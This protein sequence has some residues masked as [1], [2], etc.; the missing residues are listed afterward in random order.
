MSDFD[1]T[2]CKVHIYAKGW[3]GINLEASHEFCIHPS[4]HMIAESF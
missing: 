1:L 4:L 3:P 2:F